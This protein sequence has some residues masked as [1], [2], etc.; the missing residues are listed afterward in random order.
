VAVGDGENDV[1]LLRAAGVGVAVENAV[2]ELKAE[3]DI[4]LTAPAGDGIRMLCASLV[5]DD[6]ADLLED[7]ASRRAG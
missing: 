3:A 5:R 6:L 4:V 7:S 1:A 2:E